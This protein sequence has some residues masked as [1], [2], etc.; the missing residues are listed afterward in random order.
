MWM[1]FNRSGSGWTPNNTNILGVSY[2]TFT[3]ISM[4]NGIFAM[5]ADYD[6]DNSNG[7]LIKVSFIE[8]TG[9][10]HGVNS[11]SSSYPAGGFGRY[12]GSIAERDSGN[13]HININDTDK[14]VNVHVN[15]VAMTVLPN[16]PIDS[17][18]GLP[19]PTIA[20]GTDDGVSIIKDDG[21]VIDYTHGSSTYDVTSFV[22]FLS[23]DRV[24][25]GWDNNITPRRLFYN[26]NIIC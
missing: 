22:E 5:G 11:V 7:V 19:V 10:Y 9:Y 20:V 24:A 16:A 12:R 4:L 18:T 14:I 25:Y 17:V 6:S 21:T 3:S 15:D 8:D 13:G 23:D 1:V 2:S 26:S